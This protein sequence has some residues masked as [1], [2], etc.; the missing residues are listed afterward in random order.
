MKKANAVQGSQAVAVWDS[1]FTLNAMQ[2]P[3]K[4][5]LDSIK[6]F[7]SYCLIGT[8]NNISSTGSQADVSPCELG[9]KSPEAARSL[10]C[11]K[12]C[13]PGSLTPMGPL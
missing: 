7:L 5:A 8:G 10:S 9:L 2:R 4:N 13:P 12:H 3:L 6:S 1:F 11:P